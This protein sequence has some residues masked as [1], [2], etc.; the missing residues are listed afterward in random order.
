[1]T[2]RYSLWEAWQATPEG[3]QYEIAKRAWEATPEYEVSEAARKAW[4]YRLSENRKTAESMSRVCH[5][6]ETVKKTIPEWKAFDDASNAL[7]VTPEYRAWRD[8]LTSKALA[9]A[10]EKEKNNE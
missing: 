9:D 5:L 4:L 8:A 7:R 2:D 3:K 10:R 6:M 1:M